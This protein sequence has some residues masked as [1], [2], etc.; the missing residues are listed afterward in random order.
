MVMYLSNGTIQVRGLAECHY[1][2]PR[3]PQR[4]GWFTT[5][6]KLRMLVGSVKVSWAPGVTHSDRKLNK[7]TCI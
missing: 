2:V 4:E 1:S 3:D 7:S 6:A 5:A